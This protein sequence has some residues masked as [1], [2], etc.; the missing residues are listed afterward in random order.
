MDLLLTCVYLLGLLALALLARTTWLA[1]GRASGKK[2]DQVVLRLPPE[3]AG[4]WPLVGHL[5]LFERK[6][7]AARTLGRMADKYGPVFMIRL[8][9][10]PAMV[11]SSQETARECFTTCD[12]NFATRSRSAAGKYLA[13]DHSSI[14]LAPYGPTWRELKKVATVEVLSPA[15]LEKLRHV[16]V[17]EV[18]ICM[19]KLHQLCEDGGGR[20][21]VVDMMTFLM[22]TTF[23]IA[24]RM[25]V[26]KRYLDG[27]GAAQ[28]MRQLKKA[29]LE[30]VQL[31]DTFVPSDFVPC[32]E[33]L[34]LL[35]SIKAMKKTFNDFDAVLATWV[36]EH[37]QRKRD[38]S[39][40]DGD[41]EQDVID[42]MLSSFQGVD[43]AGLDTDTAI[44]LI[45]L[46]VIGGGM[47][48]SA[49]TM[50]WALA[51]LLNH[52]PVLDKVRHELDLHVGT[53]RNVEE[54]D[55]PNL[56]YLQA[57]LKETMR[58][59][60][61]GPFIA[62]HEAI[63]DC[64][65]GGYHVP[66]GTMLM[67]NVWKLHRD[68]HLW[69]PDPE[70]FRPERFLAG[71]E[72]ARLDVRGQQFVY[73]PFGSGRRMCPGINLALPVMQLTLAR[74]IHGF[75]LGT[76]GGAPVDMGEMLGRSFALSKAAPL[77][78]LIT[79]RLQPHLYHH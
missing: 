49:A 8:G 10:K 78:V 16:R 34:D 71:G 11:I 32:L 52:R 69:G 1:G 54:K 7:I 57:A 36:D 67:A 31:M 73:L 50:T 55:I 51:L 48:T 17:S 19:S 2:G 63:A 15:R 38:E 77:E 13:Y 39:G 64:Q 30:M 56:V 20:A 59:Y 60:P 53:T 79:P 41:E 27:S 47:D 61:F 29:L 35:G 75:E 18:D 3:P 66:A 21:K 4:A 5:L 46:A 76:P 24:V 68:P 62:P 45:L 28:Q 65:V 70:E 22:N 26:G 43:S 58:L 42:V 6:E 33:W 44:K 37:R 12:K 72:G 40:D 9:T 14:V 25:L 23:N 74:L